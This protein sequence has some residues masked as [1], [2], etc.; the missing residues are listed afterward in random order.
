MMIRVVSF[1]AHHFVSLPGTVKMYS[2][3]F[4]SI[5]LPELYTGMSVKTSTILDT[6]T[7][8]V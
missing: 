8:R 4:F 3:L 1:A 7:C 2:V 6:C 5:R